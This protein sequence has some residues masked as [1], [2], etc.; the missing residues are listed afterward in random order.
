MYSQ[1]EFKSLPFQPRFD[2][3]R[4]LGQ[5]RKSRKVKIKPEP[6][7][8]IKHESDDDDAN[9]KQIILKWFYN[10]CE[11]TSI[12]GV[13]YLGQSELHWSERFKNQNFS[14]QGRLRQ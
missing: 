1:S 9:D 5:L 11:N 12:H 10:F 8:I 7:V 13:K 4:S 2:Y 3:G 14:F 6:E